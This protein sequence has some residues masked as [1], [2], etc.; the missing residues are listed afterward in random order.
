VKKKI[1]KKNKETKLDIFIDLVQLI[2]GVIFSVYGL[3]QNN[4]IAIGIGGLL[5]LFCRR[6]ISFP[7][8]KKK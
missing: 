1:S 6:E 2:F 7:L 8:K 5:L 3:L 4:N